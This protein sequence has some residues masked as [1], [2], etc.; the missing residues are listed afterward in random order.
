MYFVSP[1]A[2]APAKGTHTAVFPANDILKLTI[3]GP[4]FETSD[5]LQDKGN[6][7]DDII[8]FVLN[9]PIKSWPVNV[10]VNVQGL[11]EF[12]QVLPIHTCVK[13][14]VMERDPLVAVL[15]ALGVAAELKLLGQE[16]IVVVPNTMPLPFPPKY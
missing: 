16:P 9:P 13:P 1:V 5:M 14:G 12:P 4:L 15:Q 7:G 2:T 8:V 10:V 11:F 6:D 3:K